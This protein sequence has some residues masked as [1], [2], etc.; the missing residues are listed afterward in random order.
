MAQNVAEKI[1]GLSSMEA[2]ADAL[3][4]T[5]NSQSGVT[6]SSYGSASLDPQFLGAVASA[7]LNKI[8]APVAGNIGVYVFQVK[9]R[10]NG[11]FYTEDDAAS[12]EAQKAQYKAQQILPVMMDDADVKD[13]RARFF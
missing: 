13:N 2:I 3:G 5:V 8:S 11:S 7:P 6:F 1:K 4:A 12:F 10:D 9:G